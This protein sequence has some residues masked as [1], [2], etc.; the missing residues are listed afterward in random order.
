[1]SRPEPSSAPERAT[2]LLRQK[3]QL[4]HG[5]QDWAAWTWEAR[6]YGTHEHRVLRFG[7]EAGTFV[8]TEPR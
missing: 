5:E 3:V 4:I 8:R 7:C 1:V 2:E 6:Q